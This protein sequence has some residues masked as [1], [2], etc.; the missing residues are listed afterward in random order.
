MAFR[1]FPW[2]WFAT[3][4]LAVVIAPLVWSLLP[5]PSGHA[6]RSRTGAWESALVVPAR[7]ADAGGRPGEVLLAYSVG[8]V[9]TAD[10]QLWQYRPDLQ[11]WLTI[12]EAF[13]QE[14][15][16][17]S[18]VPLPVPASEIAAMESFGFLVTRSGDLW[19]YVI[20]T[21]QWQKLPHPQ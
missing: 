1:R 14:G 11:Q 6:S 8:G 19:L 7:A 21:N 13:R 2:I 3:T 9:L 18:V 12:D 4:M 10:G 16:E 15:R 17:T 20:E 5:V